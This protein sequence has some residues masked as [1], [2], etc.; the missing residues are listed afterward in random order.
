MEDYR[1]KDD[2]R[3]DDF[4]H[5]DDDVKELAHALMPASISGNVKGY[6]DAAEFLLDQYPSACEEYVYGPDNYGILFYCMEYD[7]RRQQELRELV[8]DI[9]GVEVF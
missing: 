7:G 2:E 8:Y 9:S 1:Y 3:F 4:E 5:V 6:I